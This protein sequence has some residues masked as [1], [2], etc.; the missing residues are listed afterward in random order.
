MLVN[1]C[2]INVLNKCI[3]V[4]DYC[5]LIMILLSIDIRF[6]NGFAI[7]KTVVRIKSAMREV[8]SVGARR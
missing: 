6:D 7:S 2:V 4:E 5:C 8:D 3:F 1:H